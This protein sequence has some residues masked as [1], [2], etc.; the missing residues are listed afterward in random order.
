MTIKPLIYFNTSANS[1]ITHYISGAVGELQRRFERVTGIT[2][3]KLV[4]VPQFHY[5][6]RLVSSSVPVVDI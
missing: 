2:I 4:T 5:H 6:I 3:D 1:L